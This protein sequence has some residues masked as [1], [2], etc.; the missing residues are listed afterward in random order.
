MGNPKKM[1]KNSMTT[2]MLPFKI[3]TTTTTTTTTD[4][5]IEDEDCQIVYDPPPLEQS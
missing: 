3:T 2:P 5:H 1:F 4:R